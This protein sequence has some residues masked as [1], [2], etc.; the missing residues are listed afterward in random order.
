MILFE[1]LMNSEERILDQQGVLTK[2]EDQRHI[3]I[4]GGINIFL[5][6]IL[7]EASAHVQSVVEERQTYK[8]VME[9]N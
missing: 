4:I 7:V 9:D 2:E 8:N 6:R 3:Q 5:Q 1:S